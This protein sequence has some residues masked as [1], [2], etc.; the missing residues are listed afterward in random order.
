MF[1]LDLLTEHDKANQQ[2]AEERKRAATPL[3]LDEL[4]EISRRVCWANPKTE[5][6]QA[7]LGEAAAI[8]GGGE[9]Q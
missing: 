4:L 3:T 6:I 8:R 2:L 7:V 5:I 9:E 1:C